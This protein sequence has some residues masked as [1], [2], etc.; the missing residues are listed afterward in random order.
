MK[1]NPLDEVVGCSVSFMSVGFTAASHA[2]A[3]K[4]SDYGP[5][6]ARR[7]STEATR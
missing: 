6:N 1:G 3:G 7:A 4:S 2:Q 5:V